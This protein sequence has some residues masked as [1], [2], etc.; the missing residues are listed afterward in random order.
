MRIKNNQ[1]VL[2]VVALLEGFQEFGDFFLTSVD[3]ILALIKF[4][5]FCQKL[6]SLFSLFVLRN[7]LDPGRSQLLS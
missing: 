6:F 1:R 4:L 5:A 3:F 2:V 7:Q